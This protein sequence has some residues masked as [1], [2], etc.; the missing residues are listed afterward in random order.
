MM[1]I[2][3][4][5]HVASTARDIDLTIEHILTLSN[6]RMIISK[7]GMVISNLGIIPDLSVVISN[8][9]VV[10]SNLGMVIGMVCHIVISMISC[11]NTDAIS[12]AYPNDAINVP[13]SLS[14]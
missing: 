3:H 7:L 10:I 6:L 13:K 5:L 1:K 2:H 12:N 4:M 11:R 9:G 14:Q 8:L